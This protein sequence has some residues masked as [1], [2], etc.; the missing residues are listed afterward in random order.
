[1]DEKQNGFS[2]RVRLGDILTMI[3]VF[4]MALG[5]ISSIFVSYMNV[6]E[7]IGGMGE[8]I[9]TIEAQVS[10]LRDEVKARK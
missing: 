2:L 10:A 3:V 7:K 1:M 5:M 9:T 8:R 4:I 6:V